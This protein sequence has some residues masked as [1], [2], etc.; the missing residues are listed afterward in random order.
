MKA[1][2]TVADPRRTD[3]AVTEDAG[4]GG[5]HRRRRPGYVGLRRGAGNGGRRRA[6]PGGLR[7]AGRLRELVG[8]GLI[9]SFGMSLGWTVVVLVAVARGGIAEAALYNAAMLIGVVLSAPATGW[10]ARR[11]I[12]RTLLRG[13]AGVELLL[14]VGVLV[15]LVAGLPAP[16]IAV[17]ITAMSVAAWAGFAAMRAEVTAVD[18]R[19]RAMTRYAVAIAAVEAAGTGLAALLPVGPAGH[20]TGWLLVAVLIG[21]G[22]SLLPTILSARRARVAAGVR[23][24][25]RRVA[26]RSV[27]APGTLA[28]GGLVMVLASGPTLLA[29]PL[30]TELYGRTWVAGAAIAFSLGC[31]LSSAAVEAI[32]RLRLPTVPRWSLWGV[33]MLAGWIAAPVSPAAVLGAQFLAGLALTAFEGD[34]DARVAQRAP[35]AAVT[36]ALAYSAATRAMGSA[37]A[38]R[39]LPML[40][41]APAVGSASAVA[42]VVLAGAALAIWAVALIRRAGRHA[43]PAALRG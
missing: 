11:L 33:A 8:T 1:V 19:P 27:V 26:T 31:L 41:A 29:I 37:L 20:P 34:M 14:R 2:P 36:T 21:Y 35:A 23:A 16:L 22:G 12:G 32:G 40:V 9:D 6:G 30:T 38:V 25:A 18:P 43:L 39:A 17:A 42:G 28:V 4:R 13:A 10:L 7:R 3:P 5:A 15:G 24:G